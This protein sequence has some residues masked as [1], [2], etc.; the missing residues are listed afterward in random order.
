MNRCANKHYV[1][2]SQ[3]HLIIKICIDMFEKVVNKSHH[4]QSISE[5]NLYLFMY[6]YY[7]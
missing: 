6:A 2:K 4:L 3:K 1:I 5:F 7:V